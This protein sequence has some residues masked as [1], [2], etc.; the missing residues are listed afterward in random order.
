MYLVFV[1]MGYITIKLDN[2]EMCILIVCITKVNIINDFV[3]TNNN[4]PNIIIIF[5]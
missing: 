4:V 1:L 5:F 3:K 2:C